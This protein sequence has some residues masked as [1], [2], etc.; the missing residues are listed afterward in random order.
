MCPDVEA[1]APLFSAV[2]GLGGPATPTGSHPAHQL[3]VR[4]ADR[5]LRAPTPCW[6]WPRTL[7]ALAGGRGTASEVLD[8]AAAAPVRHRFALTDDDLATITCWVQ[9]S[10][11]RWGLNGSLRSTYKL[12]GFPQNTWRAGLDR[13][14]LGVAMAE[15]EGSLSARACRSTTSGA[16]R[17]TS[18]ARWPSWSARLERRVTGLRAAPTLERVARPA[19]RRRARPRLGVAARDTWQV[20][21]LER[22]LDEVLEARGRPT[23]ARPSSGSPTCARSSSSAAA[24]PH[25]RELPHRQPHGRHAGADALGAR[26][27]S[28]A[29]SA[30]T[31]ACSPART[32]SDGDD[33]LAR[34]PLTGERD[35]RSEDRQLLLDAVLAAGETLVVTY[36]GANEHSGQERPPAVP[37]G[38]LLDTLG[39]DE[40][41][42]P[43]PGPRA[44]P[45]PA[46]RRPELRRRAARRPPGR[47][48]STG[49]RSPA[50]AASHRASAGPWPRSWTAA[51]P[52]REPGDVS[53]ADLQAFLRAPGRAASCGSGS[54]SA[55]PR[56]TTRSTTRCR[57]SWTR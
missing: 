56:S 16:R 14:L 19:A 6:R 50:A 31:T 9:Q 44:T 43:G 2:F 5:G 20:A 10:G 53:L 7:V 47:S 1:Y 51:L 17:S 57:W 22:E 55:S 4:L 12:S 34:D 8:L 15:E 13:L 30:S 11:V 37:L 29:W 38:E 26:T 42:R 45:A 49:R 27:G 54:T 52:A 28:C 41:R 24:A 3:R 35:A 25:A 39:A 18:P 33:V 36:T 40:P 21:Q 23:G 48:A 32:I 46:V